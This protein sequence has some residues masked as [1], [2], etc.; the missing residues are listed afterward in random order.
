MDK[1]SILAMVICLFIFIGWMWLSQKIW[2]APPQSAAKK[3]DAAAPVP[4]PAPDKPAPDKPDVAKPVP[5]AVKT[6]ER[7]RYAEKPPF[8]LR[9]AQGERVSAQD[10]VQKPFM[11]SLSKHERR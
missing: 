3:P 9:H 6:A 1:R 5:D 10:Y 2:P 4:K 7:S 8:T 11:L